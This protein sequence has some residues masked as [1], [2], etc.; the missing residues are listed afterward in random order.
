ME[1]CAL[2]A[3]SSSAKLP[4]SNPVPPKKKINKKRIYKP[5]DTC[6][7]MSLIKKM[8]KEGVESI[9]IQIEGYL[10]HR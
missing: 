4:S 5:G 8:L 10:I 9:M 2:Q 3:Q 6:L 7:R 1:I